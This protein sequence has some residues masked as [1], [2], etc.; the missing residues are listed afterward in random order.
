MMYDWD[1]LILFGVI[2]IGVVI[3]AGNKKV[4][5]KKGREAMNILDER[6]AKGEITKEEYMERKETINTYKKK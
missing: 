5:E 1:F 4:K 2:I 3:Y 6:Y